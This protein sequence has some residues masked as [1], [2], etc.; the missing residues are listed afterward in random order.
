MKTAE[1]TIE[2]LANILSE[3]NYIKSEYIEVYKEVFSEV[4]KKL[5][6]IVNE[7]DYSNKSKILRGIDNS[8]E[9]TKVLMQFPE[10][11]GK[12]I[13]GIVGAVGEANEIVMRA[14]SSN[15]SKKI[16]MNNTCIPNIIYNDEDENNIKIVNL[17]E[18][19]VELDEK[20]FIKVNRE[21]YKKKIDIKAFLSAFSTPTKLDVKDTVFI[22]FPAYALKY[23]EYYKHLLGK[24][25]SFLVIRDDKKKYLDNIT[26]LKRSLKKITVFSKEENIVVAKEEIENLKEVSIIS[27]SGLMNFILENNFKINNLDVLNKFYLILN[28]ITIDMTER[29]KSLKKNIEKMAKDMLSIEDEETDE[30]LNAVRNNNCKKLEIV[31]K[32][33]NLYE[34]A[35][36][37]VI[38]KIELFEKEILEKAQIKVE[39]CDLNYRDINF[40]IRNRMA[41]LIVSLIESRQV[42]KAKKYIDI[43]EK[44][45]CEYTYLFELYSCAKNRKKV[46]ISSIE[47]LMVEKEKLD[48]VNKLKVMY[49]TEINLTVNEFREVLKCINI[50]MLD[51]NSLE[52]LGDWCKRNNLNE[53]R[54]YEKAVEKGNVKAG[55][56]IVED[57]EIPLNVLERL[58]NRLIPSANYKYGM[59]CIEK[60]Q[61]AKGMTNLKIAAI[62]KNA[63][64]IFELADIEYNRNGNRLSDES[65]EI[66]K[67]L[68]QYLLNEGY[69]DGIIY[70]RLG[71]ILYYEKNYIRASELLEKSNTADGLYLAGRIYQYGD[72]LSQDLQHTKNLFSKAANKG[73]VR[74]SVEYEKVCG[75]IES[76]EIKRDVYRS[77]VDYSTT[78]T[79]TP[80][81]SSG[82]CFL[83]TATCLVLGKPDECEELVAFKKYRDTYLINENDGK[84]L[85]REYY[86]IAPEILNKIDEEQ[87][88]K[89]VYFK[90][91]D[92]Y[93]SV[94]YRYLLEKEY[95]KAKEIYIKMVVDLCEKYKVKIN[96]QNY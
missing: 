35:K 77:G 50:D 9:E 46:S 90:M 1:E 83:T 94:G 40:D 54:Y 65:A 16:Y 37:Q 44:K 45:N 42:A 96:M 10:L 62:Y 52:K 24:V 33:I 66:C 67:I 26:F 39:E 85:I 76:N 64:A 20:E 18:N 14:I 31:N 25:N 32:E 49:C 43:L 56:K 75:W 23:K 79:S 34:N 17:I 48:I 3:K 93:I 82:G 58:A 30:I 55:E 51:G 89:Q 72:K 2:L 7:I 27:E 81:G 73:H 71:T 80:T 29:R 95:K 4:R 28:E 19:Y 36:K 59:I 88:S 68:Y 15:E 78:R 13:V 41:N 61:Y 53:F 57:E 74:A 6:G 91:Y 70:E 5:I 69:K 11:I 63:D 47:K 8:I 22:Y 38:L 12:N 86:R 84:Q 92:D 87:D 21:L 60:N